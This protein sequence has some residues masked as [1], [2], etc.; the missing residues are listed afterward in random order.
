MVEEATCARSWLLIEA[1]SEG[2]LRFATA[3]PSARPRVTE[4][5]EINIAG[6]PTF[7]DALQNYERE[8]GIRLRGMRCAMAIAG[9]SSG[10]SI[11]LV[12]SRWTISRGGLAAFFGTDPVILNDVAARAWAVRSGSGMTEQLRGSASPTFDR[13][14]RYGMIMAEEGV[15][16]AIIDVGRDGSVHVLE[17]EAGH[18]DFVPASEREEALAKALRGANTVVSWER[19]LMLDRLDPVWSVACADMLEAERPRMLA[20]MLGRFAVNL[21]HSF[22]AWQGMMLTGSRTGRLL[23]SDNRMHFGSAFSV[24][25][26]FSRLV[27]S[28]PAWRID[29]HEAVLTGT[30]ERL[31]HELG[32]ELRVAA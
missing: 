25:R 3:A 4:V 9:A 6:V 14:G 20:A 18:T 21:M 17:T 5:L 8:K 29:Q 19:L 28:A 1:S 31:A 30:A 2:M 27:A 11:S 32:P 13:P 7:T 24:R 26:N 10:E 15:G 16:A 22:G 23:Q 12:R